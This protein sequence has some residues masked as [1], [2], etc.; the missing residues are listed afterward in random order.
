MPHSGFKF[1][2]DFHFHFHFHFYATL[3]QIT[4]HLCYLTISSSPRLEEEEEEEDYNTFCRS[5]FEEQL[6]LLLEIIE[7]PSKKREMPRTSRTAEVAARPSLRGP[8]NQ[9][10]SSADSDPTHVRPKTERSPKIAEGRTQRGT[11]SNPLHQKKLRTRIADLESQLGLAQEELKSLKGHL[12]STG[13]AKK[14]VQ[15]QLE[16]KP[17]KSQRAPEPFEIEEKHLTPAEARKLS[18]KDSTKMYE[19]SEEIQEETD[20]FEVPNEKTTLEPKAEPEDDELKAKSVSLSA[21]SPVTAE[22]ESPCDELASKEEEINLLKARLEEKGK[23]LEVFRQENE[24]IKSQLDEKSLKISSAQSE[25]NSLNKRL[26]L[27]SEELEKSKSSSSQMNEKL[28][29]TEKEKELLENEMK[30]LRVQTEQWRKAADAAA[31]VLAG[32]AE[33]N[34]RR[35]SERCGSMDKL[36][37]N[38]FDHVGGYTGY[39]GSPGLMEDRDDVFGGEKRKSIKMFGDL[40]KKKSHK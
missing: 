33:A 29:A 15:D 27:A 12:V 35:I 23:E 7:F 26:T 6:I 10:T 4:I 18:K 19:A 32:D 31:S 13:T 16:R 24:S 22:P 28:E 34:G 38:T 14:A 9:R 37:V 30:M 3:L 21:E 17:K 1:N 20:V 25:I 2:A 39:V 40:W 36:Y 11:L 5:K 8:A